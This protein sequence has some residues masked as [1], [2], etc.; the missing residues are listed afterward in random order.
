MSSA[1]SSRSR[2]LLGAGL[3]ALGLG[4]T[5]EPA[6]AQYDPW[7]DQ[8]R[9]QLINSAIAAGYSGM[10]LSHEPYTDALYNGQNSVV[11]LELDGGMTYVIVGACDV[12]CSD[13]DLR[14]FDENWNVVD[15]D[16]L[17]NDRPIVAVTPRHTAVFHARATMA[18]C[19]SSP[20]AMGFGVFSR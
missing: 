16:R 12:D 7:T 4:L 13:L 10:D 5:P 8:V 3:V 20:C 15:D 9:A 14:L 19:Q 6:S 2:A 18:R 17:A 11:D 1:S